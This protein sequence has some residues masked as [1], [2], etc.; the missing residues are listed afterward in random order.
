MMSTPNNH[1][2]NSVNTSKALD[3]FQWYLQEVAEY[4]YVLEVSTNN[5]L[6]SFV[7]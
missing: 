6:V 3:L 2:M 7:T 5:I 4:Q 1:L